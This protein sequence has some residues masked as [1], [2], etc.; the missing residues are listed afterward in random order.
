[1]STRPMTVVSLRIC[2]RLPPCRPA[3]LPHRRQQR[4]ESL[5]PGGGKDRNTTLG[6]VKT[7]RTPFRT[8]GPISDRPSKKAGFT[9]AQLRTTG[10]ERQITYQAQPE[11]ADGP[12]PAR[13][14]VKSGG[15]CSQHIRWAE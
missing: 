15:S 1:M 14:Q 5:N 11:P 12:L 9:D 13:G 6:R 10:Q 7:C 3:Q 2:R 8:Y 4:I